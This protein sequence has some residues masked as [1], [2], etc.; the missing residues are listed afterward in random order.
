MFILIKF[1]FM[2]SADKSCGQFIYFFV[3][4]AAEQL[5]QKSPPPLKAAQV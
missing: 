5:A 4:L 1:M 2:V 3:I